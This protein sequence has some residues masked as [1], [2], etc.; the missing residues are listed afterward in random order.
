MSKIYVTRKIPDA[1]VVFLRSK[2][3]EVD[4]SKKSGVL[5]REELVAALTEKAYDAVLCLLT[6]KIDGEIFDA[7]PRAKI[8]ANYAV[9]FDNI[10]LNAAKER[11]VVVTNTPSVL[12][13]T[14]AEHTFTLMLAIAHRVVEADRFTRAGKYIGW[15]PMMLLGND[16]SGK[17]VGIIGLGRIGSRVAHHAA[18]GFDAKVIYTDVARNEAFEKESG[19]EYRAS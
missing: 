8:F 5:T 11:G 13:N 4:V 6:D 1:G 16:L 7:A 3:H 10:D 18:K 14:V 19:A 2:G 17:I 15:A 9:G 12:T